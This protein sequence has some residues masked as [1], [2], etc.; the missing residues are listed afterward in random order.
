MS[1]S[2]GT[3]RVAAA[4]NAIASS[5]K[6][7]GKSLPMTNDCENHVN[8]SSMMMSLIDQDLSNESESPPANVFEHV[9]DKVSEEDTIKDLSTKPSS[10]NPTPSTRA[11]SCFDTA[12]ST[13][14]GSGGFS[15]LSKASSKNKRKKKTG[16]ITEGIRRVDRMVNDV[17]IR[18]IEID[19]SLSLKDVEFDRV[20]EHKVLDLSCMEPR[21]H[22]L[23]PQ[24]LVLII[25]GERVPIDEVQNCITRLLFH[26][27]LMDCD[28]KNA[29]DTVIQDLG[30]IGGFVAGRQLIKPRL[31]EFFLRLPKQVLYE[32][33]QCKHEHF[34][35]CLR[36]AI[37]F[38]GVHGGQYHVTHWVD[39]E[40]IQTLMKATQDWR[41]DN[42]FAK[43]QLHAS[44][45]GNIIIFIFNFLVLHLYLFIGSTDE[46]HT[47]FEWII[48]S[49]G[50]CTIQDE[51]FFKKC[52]PYLFAFLY[53]RLVEYFDEDKKYRFQVV[54]ITLTYS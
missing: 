25:D 29:I 26:Y 4:L 41:P 35:D 45:N 1:T 28:R 30:L 23:R 42:T 14:K 8:S 40:M 19:C 39:D 47:I 6:L 27:M 11:S 53:E 10:T 54:Y 3:K 52:S 5:K 9:W 32:P 22:A 37:S 49:V 20:V 15:A 36:K 7:K 31:Y 46:P 33:S 43:Q 24:Q 21:L 18:E 44:K 13:V 48:L 16:D 12:N 38:L 17:L 51:D 34:K 50:V 2:K